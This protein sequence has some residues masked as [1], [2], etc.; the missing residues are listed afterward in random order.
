MT[1]EMRWIL[2]LSLGCFGFWQLYLG[3]FK[4]NLI[5]GLAGALLVA[6]AVLFKTGAMDAALPATSENGP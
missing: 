2:G 1:Y 3:V 6:G 5:L 4:R